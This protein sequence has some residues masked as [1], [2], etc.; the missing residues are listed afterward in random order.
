MD[1]NWLDKLQALRQT[2]PQSPMENDE[3]DKSEVSPATSNTA[4]LDIILDKKGRAGKKATI[5]AGWNGTDDELMELAA[6]LKKKL[7]AGGSAR[8]GEILIQGDR[9]A[10]IE[11]ELKTFGHKCRI[12]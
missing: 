8:G 7:A 2:L 6:K 10:Q 12:I 1:N 4:R 3:E 5:V 9:R 11:T